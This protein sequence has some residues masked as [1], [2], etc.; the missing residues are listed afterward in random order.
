MSNHVQPSSLI[1]HPRAAIWRSS[2]SALAL[3]L[4]ACGGGGGSASSV[5]GTSGD[6]IV[7]Q[8]EPA[9]NGKLFLNEPIRIDF[10]NEVDITSADLNS[11]SFQ[12][13]D[14]TGKPIS[15]QPQGTFRLAASAGDANPGRR[16]EF[17]PRFPTN[18]SFDNGGFRPGRRYL[19]NLIGGDT[20]NGAVLRDVRGKTMPAPVTFAFTTANGSSPAQ[21]FRDTKAGGPRRSGFSVVPTIS[22]QASLNLLGQAP[23][24]V[25]LKFDQPLNP[26]STN[27]MSTFDPDPTKRSLSQRGRIFLEYDDP[28]PL[29]GKN[30]WIPSDIDF[31]SNQI[32]GS[33]LV[34]RPVGVLPNNATIRVI[35][36]NTLE[37]MAGESNIK[38]AAYNRVFATFVT[39]SSYEPVFDGVAE[40]FGAATQIDTLAPFVEPRAELGAGYLRSNFE[41][42]GQTTILEYEPAQAV[43]ELNTDFTQITPKGAPPVNVTGG[44][45]NFARVRI[46]P[47]VR[48]V[49][50]GSKPMVWLVTGDFIVDGE[51]F[52]NGSDGANAV[53]VNSANIPTAGGPGQCSGG[54]GGRGSP[55]TTGPSTFGESGFGPGQVAGTGGRGGQQSCVSTC[56]KGSG[57]GGGS[58]LTQG[59]PN[60]KVK[61][62]NNSFIQQRGVGGFGCIGGSGATTRNL[63]GGNPGLLLFTDVRSDNNFWGSAVNVFKQVRIQGEFAVP[64]GGQGGGGGGDRSPICGPNPNW[65]A[66]NKGGGGGGGAGVLV[67]KA[68][69]T[70]KI[71]QTGRIRA[72]GG[73]GGGGEP[74]GGNTQGAG[75]GAGSGGMVILM[76]GRSIDITQHGETYLNN[77]YDFAV[78]ADGGMGMQGGFGGVP[79]SGKYPP[80]STSPLQLDANP[81]GAMGGLGVVQLLAPAGTNTDGTNTILDDGVILRDKNGSVVTGAVKQRYLAWRGYPTDQGE[82][83]DDNGT[84]ITG[85]NEGDGDIRPAPLLMPAPFGPKSRA[86]SKWIDA[87]AAVRR[88]VEGA[89]GDG[90]PR[91]IRRQPGS[92]IYRSGPE[93]SFAGTNANPGSGYVG[94]VD[95]A[96]PTGSGEGVVLEFPQPP[97]LVPVLPAA[98]ASTSATGSFEGRPAYIVDLV[99]SVLG[100]VDHR[101]AQHRA[102]LQKGDG[103]VLGEFRILGHNRGPRGDRLYLGT[104]G[105]QLPTGVQ[106]L[107]IRAKFFDLYTDGTPGLGNAYRSNSRNVPYANV[108]LGFA[109]HEDAT[110]A[111][112]KGNDT[113]RYPQAVGTFVYDL[114]S[115]SEQIRAQKMPFVQYEIEFNTLFSETEPGNLRPNAQMSPSD[116]RQE[117]RFLV[118]PYRF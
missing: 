36:E 79:I 2:A 1:Q 9:N 7:L 26:S 30:T 75:G 109:F 99:D 51:L 63:P 43:V 80:A 97:D 23:L 117:L 95:Y 100:A 40:A 3:L 69:G 56:G 14:A 15:E 114:N 10:S 58:F 70:I 91:G 29:K 65:I 112:V 49:G 32:E 77:D 111:L 53:S 89:S 87:G 66:D 8:T 98:V 90:Q 6:F 39:N 94:Y 35:V 62:S 54:S 44:V 33:E 28:D 38:D 68:L 42:E 84:K 27:V 5:K 113:K 71:S 74:S 12:V 110:Q 85:V 16:L 76:A 101:W 22:G 52:V 18:D 41:F 104:G 78:S 11:F 67:I 81:L 37:D 88:E 25:K 96:Q 17:V 19:V 61:A 102:I 48:V 50:K 86:R 13:F 60:Y 92:L 47:G 24:E 116:P 83:V 46:P 21:L 73:H 59:D 82:F 64:S 115:V 72:D 107:D 20:R 4:A 93:Y 45:F 118:L 106:K 105:G 108:K 103:S 57:G 31:E 34:L 55:N